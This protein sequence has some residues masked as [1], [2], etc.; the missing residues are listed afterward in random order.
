MVQ[1]Q[2][3]EDDPSHGDEPPEEDAVPSRRSD[4]VLADPAVAAARAA[5]PP[6]LPLSPPSPKPPDITLAKR[7]PAPEGRLRSPVPDTVGKRTPAPESEPV[8]SSAQ[9]WREAPEGPMSVAGRRS[10]RVA[11]L[12]Y[13]HPVP[14]LLAVA[15]LTAV[16][17]LLASRLELLTGFENLLPEDRKSVGELRRVAAHTAGVST[18]FV[19]LEAKGEGPSLSEPLRRAGDALVAELRQVGEPW[20]GSADDGVQD[21]V[22]FLEPRVGLYADLGELQKLKA[23]IDA[24][25]EYEVQKASD[26]LLED[27]EPP[28]AALDA[29]SIRKRFGVEGLGTDSAGQARYPDGYFESADGRTLVVTVRSKVLGSDADRAGETVRRVRAAIERVDLASYAPELGYAFA[30]DLH[31]SWVEVQAI[32]ED[33]TDVGLVGLGLITG[34]VLLYYLRLRTLVLMLLT[35]GIGVAWTFGL[36]RLT[37]GHLN[38]ATGF[39]FTIIAGNGINFGILYMARY[40]EARR[41]GVGVEQSLAVAH[42]ETWLPTLCAASAAAASYGSLLATEFRGFRDFGLIGSAGMVLCWI[43]TFAALPAMLVLVE[44]VAPIDATREGF[45]ASMR[46]FWEASYGKPFALAARVAP[47]LITVVGLLAAIAGFAGLYT[48]IARDPMDYDLDNL[49]NEHKSRVEEERIK[50]RA[51]DITG[52]VGADGMAILVDAPEQVPALRDALYA[53]RDA[54]PPE[55]KPFEA[56]HALE[57][58][59]PAGDQ[60]AKIPVLLD[61]KKKLAR[62][63]GF[64]AITDDDWKKLA[65]Y[66]PP[67]DLAPIAMSDLPEDI[68]RPFTE[69]D[70]TRGRIVYISPAASYRTDDDARY[71][72]RWA[73]SYRETTLPDGSVVL[74][75]GRAVIYADM[76]AAVRQAVPIAVT[77]SFLAT[78]VAVSVYFRFRRA[79]LLVLGSLLVGVGWLVGIFVIFDIKVNF[80]N[81]IA[82]PITFG[83]GVDYAVNIVHRYERQGYRGVLHAVRE[84]GGAVV[85]C[86]LTTTLGYLALIK[87]LNFAVRSL[88][89]AAVVGELCCILAAVLVLPAALEWHA[90]VR[91]ARRK[92]R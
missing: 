7:S 50:E 43:A 49:R 66:L 73:D 41:K 84:T 90:T 89:I 82:L 55:Q 56:V 72:L 81:F 2:T 24:R 83:I 92:A 48:F 16:A 87:S 13:R 59:V 53:R 25:Y 86:S 70:G 30:G 40:L 61:I 42:R 51:D 31:S 44:R 11:G 85:L 33:L 14:V 22:R 78:V 5:A 12:Q 9:S 15:A 67:D 23:D 77:L 88:G 28:G 8:P 39:L 35:V 64:K 26:M 76:F 46:R 1:D 18:L 57:D 6:H 65:R 74:G 75:S 45:V 52:Y 32:H 79:A 68:A 17:I 91:R 37:I 71:L 63:H 54:V 38:I 4:H 19:V 20:V 29:A 47:R 80:L 3:R 69:V 27:A 10:H 58:F 62:I 21:A 34:I 36:T 60:Q